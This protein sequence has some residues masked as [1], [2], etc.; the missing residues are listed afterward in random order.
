MPGD[1][2]V[3]RC[4]S[5]QLP[6]HDLSA[7][8][9][10]QAESLVASHPGGLCARFHRR[11]DG[12]IA[13]VDGTAPPLGGAA[14]GAQVPAA[15][16]REPRRSLRWLAVAAGAV[17]LAGQVR[18]LSTLIDE[19]EAAT[20]PHADVKVNEEIALSTLDVFDRHVEHEPEPPSMQ[21]EPPPM[22]IELI[23]QIRE[24]KTMGRILT[25]EAA[26][27]IHELF[28]DDGD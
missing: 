23:E 1:E 24:E 12:T 18:V 17:G 4:Q 13:T 9:R 26:G 2:R 11:A 27:G 14:G 15:K 3:R 7:M 25:V 19:P 20:A 28:R 22:K 5:C 21:I 10:A 8:T 16:D 6:V